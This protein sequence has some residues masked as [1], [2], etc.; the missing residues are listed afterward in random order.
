MDADEGQEKADAGLDRHHRADERPVAEFPDRGGELAGIGDDA[1]ASDEADDDEERAR[2]PKQQ[3]NHAYRGQE[4]HAYC[5]AAV[6]TSGHPPS[7][8]GRNA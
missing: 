2:S 6:S 5:A 7:R 8:S 4:P 3:A 1:N